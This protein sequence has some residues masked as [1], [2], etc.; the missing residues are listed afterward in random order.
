VAGEAVAFK[1]KEDIAAEDADLLY[2]DG[3]LV[4]PDEIM[5]TPKKNG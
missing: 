4:P 5:G 3:G 2:G 1:S